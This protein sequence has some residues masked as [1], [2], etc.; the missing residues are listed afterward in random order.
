[1]AVELVTGSVHVRERETDQGEGRMG[2]RRRVLVGHLQEVDGEAGGGSGGLQS[3]QEVAHGITWE[4]HAAAPCESTKKTNDFA[5][6]S[7]ALESFPGNFENC[8][9]LHHLMIPFV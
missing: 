8:T 1:M 6:G 4:L 9:C 7:L 2:G 5:K 3:K